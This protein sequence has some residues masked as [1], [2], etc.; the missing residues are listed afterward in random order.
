MGLQGDYFEGA[1]A[2]NLQLHKDF[3][4][5]KLWEFS[6][7]E[8]NSFEKRLNLSNNFNAMWLSEHDAIKNFFAI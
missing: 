2:A 3:I 4:K 7:A 6:M 8:L 1:V 5:C